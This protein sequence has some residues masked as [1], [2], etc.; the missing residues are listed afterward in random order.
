MNIICNKWVLAA[1]FICFSFTCLSAQPTREQLAQIRVDKEG[2]FKYWKNDAASLAQLK[3]FVTAVTTEGSEQ[4]VPVRDRLAVFD[5][6]GT[7][8]CET[9]P[10]Y[11]NWLVM[12]HR[13]LDDTSYTPTEELRRF[14]EAAKAGMYNTQLIDREMDDRAQ[15]VQTEIFKGLTMKEMDAWPTKIIVCS[16]GPNFA[17][18]PVK[19]LSSLLMTMAY[20]DQTQSSGML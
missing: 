7:L 17:T 3:S 18:L 12:L 11:M 4:Y 2:N 10:F 9:A 1:T 13:L 8:L 6:D 20:A 14:G 16:S 15:Y 19:M 5:M